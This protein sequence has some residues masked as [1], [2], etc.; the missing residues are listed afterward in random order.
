MNATKPSIPQ[1]LTKRKAR[2]HYKNTTIRGRGEGITYC[3]VCQYCNE[4]RNLI[5]VR[6]AGGDLFVCRKHAAGG[7]Q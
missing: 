3:N 6:R 7:V 4:T 5:T 2:E 1:A